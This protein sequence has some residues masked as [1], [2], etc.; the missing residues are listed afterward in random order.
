V[1]NNLKTIDLCVTAFQNSNSALGYVPPEMVE[2]VLEA[3]R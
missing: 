2:Q 3:V 1:P